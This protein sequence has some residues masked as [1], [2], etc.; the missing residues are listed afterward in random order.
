M[1]KNLHDGLRSTIQSSLTSQ[2]VTE[3][4]LLAHSHN[5]M[6]GLQMNSSNYASEGIYP[7]M[8]ILFRIVE[9]HHDI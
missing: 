8:Q 6:E 2:I 5:K 1:Q 9:P 4:I 3:D 7:T